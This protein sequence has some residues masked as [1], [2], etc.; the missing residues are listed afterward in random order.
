M[1]KE[2]NDGLDLHEKT[3][4]SEKFKRLLGRTEQPALQARVEK[5]IA[6]V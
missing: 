1:F 4:I 6:L 5:C 3:Q 2:V